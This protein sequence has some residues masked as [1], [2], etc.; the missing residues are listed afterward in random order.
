MYF[1]RRTYYEDL[2]LEPAVIAVAFTVVFESKSF[3][4]YVLK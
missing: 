4:I 3:C 2:R 1:V